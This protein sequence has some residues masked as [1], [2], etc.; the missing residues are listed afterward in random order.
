MS[1]TNPGQVLIQ[2]PVGEK[3]PSRLEAQLRNGILTLM[4]ITCPVHK[5]NTSLDAVITDRTPESISV[6]LQACCEAC[7]Q[8]GERALL[9]AAAAN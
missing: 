8:R 6:E 7:A 1:I 2:F 5:S 3:D 4:D 9:Q